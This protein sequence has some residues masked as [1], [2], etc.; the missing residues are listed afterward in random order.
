[1]N[2][3]GIEALNLGENGA[4]KNI[5]ASIKEL[6]RNQNKVQSHCIRLNPKK[7]IPLKE[8]M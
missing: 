4:L 6:A 7:N 8:D 3:N 2:L 1:M 5:I